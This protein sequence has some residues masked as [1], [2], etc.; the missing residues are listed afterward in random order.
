MQK[1]QQ[2]KRK[3]SRIRLRFFSI[4]LFILIIAVIGYYFW[5]TTNRGIPNLHGWESIEVLNFA[6]NHNIDI[7]FEFVYSNNM[8]PTLVISQSVPPG[9]IITEGMSLTVEISKGIRV[10]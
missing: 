5:Q 6:N 2:A 1:Q 10:R 9:T 7:H 4:L 8:A 3:K